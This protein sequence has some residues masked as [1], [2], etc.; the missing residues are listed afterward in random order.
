MRTETSAI[1][2]GVA[3]LGVK[4][5]FST[6]NSSPQTTEL[7]AKK[8]APTLM[9]WVNIAAA[10]SVGLVGCLAL[11]S[12][13]GSRHWPI[14]GGIAGLAVTYGMYVHAKQCGLKSREEGT[15]DYGPTTAGPAVEPGKNFSSPHR[16][17]T[18]KSVA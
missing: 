14:L 7:N 5:I 15:E 11:A 4:D 9:K 12:P 6:D 10:E 8:R 18:F 17:R 13:R 1:A 3:Y 2:F 16:T